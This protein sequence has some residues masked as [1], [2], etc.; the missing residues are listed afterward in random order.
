MRRALQILRWS[1][2]IGW[3]M[4]YNWTRKWIY[5]LYAAVRPL[6]LCLILYYI[7]K[8]FAANPAGHRAF[9]SIFVGNA[10]FNIFVAV[11]SGVSWSVIQDREQYRIIRYIYVSPIPFW[12]YILGR[13]MI[14]LLISLVSLL[15]VL[16]FGAAVLGLP[17]GFSH[18]SLPMAL[19]STVFGIVSASAFGLIF[20]G[21]VL[22]TARHSMLLAEGAGAIFLLLCGVIY[23]IDFMPAWAQIVGLA[24]PMTY[25]MELVRRAFGGFNFS[26]ILAGLSDAAIMLRLGILTALFCAA[27]YG[28]FKL[29]ENFAKSRGKIDETT[30]Y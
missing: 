2:W 29:A 1:M 28:A 17:I 4:E 3:E 23:P 18:V 20:A 7:Y 9:I 19:A 16:A 8:F 10:F 25:W 13:A 21:L 6:S 12:L 11:A 30:N 15:I 26:P 27:S 14:V 5:F 22:V 24:A